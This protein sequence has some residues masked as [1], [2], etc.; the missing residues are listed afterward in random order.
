MIK[1]ERIS[2]VQF[3]S[4]FPIFIYNLGLSLMTLSPDPKLK[5]LTF[6]GPE[7]FYSL[8]LNVQSLICSSPI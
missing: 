2:L 4:N 5:K 1:I 3:K 6:L 8:I 7:K